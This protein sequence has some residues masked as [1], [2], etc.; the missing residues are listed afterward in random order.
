MSIALL[1]SGAVFFSNGGLFAAADWK[2]LVSQVQSELAHYFPDQE[3]RRENFKVFS[4]YTSEKPVRMIVVTETA[5]PYFREYYPAILI[6][7]NGASKPVL[8]KK[9]KRGKP[10]QVFFFDSLEI[11]L[12]KATNLVLQW[13][14]DLHLEGAQRLEWKIISE[15]MALVLQSSEVLDIF[16]AL[17]YFSQMESVESIR[18]RPAAMTIFTADEIFPEE[19]GVLD[20]KRLRISDPLEFFKGLKNL[21]AT[22]PCP[23][24]LR[25]LPENMDP[26]KF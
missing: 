4:T 22:P 10:A 20:F 1:A 9:E 19:A 17:R 23:G 21:R 24:F 6:S 8:V 7:E 15:G 12:N 3:G 11:H 13:K 26:S 2:R 16:L 18:L 25:Q 14:R 5:D